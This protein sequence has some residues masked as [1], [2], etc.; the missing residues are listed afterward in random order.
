MGYAI[1]PDSDTPVS[2]WNERFRVDWYNCGEGFNGDYNPE[3]PN[4][5]NFL[6]FDVYYMNDGQW[7]EVEDASYCTTVPAT[8]S[9]IR[10]KNLLEGILHE[11]SLTDY[12]N[13]SVKKLGES[14]SWIS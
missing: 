3:D 2:V 7:E 9:P 8:E 12:P 5:I 13:C 10:L 4:D 11:Y 1:W 14:L 6:R